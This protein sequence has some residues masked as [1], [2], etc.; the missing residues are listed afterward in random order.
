MEGAGNASQRQGGR[1]DRGRVDQW[2]DQTVEEG[3]SKS[4]FLGWVRFTWAAQICG[5]ILRAALQPPPT[6]HWLWGRPAGQLVSGQDR[7]RLPI[8]YIYKA[9]NGLMLVK[10]HQTLETN[11]FTIHS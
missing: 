9:Q 3:G 5:N 8:T 2:A 1:E 11:T 4:L 10:G 7:A 6:M